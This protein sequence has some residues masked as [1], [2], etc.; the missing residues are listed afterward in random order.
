MQFYNTEQNIHMH[1]C[2]LLSSFHF[3]II[4]SLSGEA[5]LML[6]DTQLH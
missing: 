2:C 1:S 6:Y 5:A 3:S 4:L